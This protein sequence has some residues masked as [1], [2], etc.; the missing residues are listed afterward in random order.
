MTVVI[1]KFFNIAKFLNFS[2]YFYR[3]KW[4]I[5]CS[6]F[7]STYPTVYTRSVQKVSDLCAIVKVS[8]R[9]VK[10]IIFLHS[11]YWGGLIRAWR[12]FISGNFY[13]YG[14]TEI[15]HQIF[16]K[17]WWCSNENNP[18]D[19]VVLGDVGL[20]PIQIKQWCN[21]LKM[22]ESQWRLNSA[23][24]GHAQVEM[25][26]WRMNSAKFFWF[27]WHCASWICTRRP[28]NWQ[29]VLPGGFTLTL[30]SCEKKAA[31]HVENKNFLLHHDYAPAHSAHVI[32]NFL[33]K[34]GM[35][36]VRQAPYSPDLAPCNFWLSLKLKTVTGG[37]QAKIA[38]KL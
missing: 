28:S 26:K 13:W 9:L 34:S 32:H 19:P 23:Q 33:A 22:A 24:G 10:A 37:H 25:K 2:N 16:S 14:G 5:I 38:K 7:V 12:L 31:R 3:A 1:E 8:S 6:K 18:K 21:A 30:C 15:L 35:P 17:T 4:L 27:S 29:R 36:F 11:I 20:S